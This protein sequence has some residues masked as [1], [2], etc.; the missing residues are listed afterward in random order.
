MVYR[1][2][3]REICGLVANWY[4][5]RALILSELY[6]AIKLR[7]LTPSK[8]PTQQA[9]ILRNGGWRVGTPTHIYQKVD[10]VIQ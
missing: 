9:E 3:L 7:F 5:C 10:A 6:P 4:S 2:V 8:R 1:K